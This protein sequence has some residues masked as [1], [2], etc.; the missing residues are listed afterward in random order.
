MDRL[1]RPRKRPGGTAARRRSPVGCLITESA[2]APAAA[3]VRGDPLN[4]RAAIRRPEIGGALEHN[5]RSQYLALTISRVTSYTSLLRLAPYAAPQHPFDSCFPPEAIAQLLGAQIQLRNNRRL[6]AAMR[7]S[8]LPAIKRLTECDFSSIRAAPRAAGE[9]CTSSA[10]P[11]AAKTSSSSGHRASA[12][13][14]SRSA[15]R[16]TL[17]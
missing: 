11:N 5:S 2:S 13:R 15:W 14:L 10:S 4:S 16:L 12:R 6:Q 3:L 1:G 7:S 9:V 8:R 17:R